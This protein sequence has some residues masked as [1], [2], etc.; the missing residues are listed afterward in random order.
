MTVFSSQD[1]WSRVRITD[2]CP[3]AFTQVPCYAH[4]LLLDPHTLQIPFVRAK[5]QPITSTTNRYMTLRVTYL[6]CS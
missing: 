3:L 4:M 1:P 6:I 2:N 5:N